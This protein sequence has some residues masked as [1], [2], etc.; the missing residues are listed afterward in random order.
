[1]IAPVYY[2]EANNRGDEGN[3]QGGI[4]I[5]FS[6]FGVQPISGLRANIVIAARF[7]FREDSFVL[8]A[9]IV[10]NFIG[11]KIERKIENTTEQTDDTC[12]NND[13]NKPRSEPQQSTCIAHLLSRQ[14]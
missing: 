5:D 6:S 8:G 7:S 14:P 11:P 12:Q 2:E 3:D 4:V 10:M 13:E 9:N 1:M